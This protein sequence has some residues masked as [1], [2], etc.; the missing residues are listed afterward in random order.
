ML[1]DFGFWAFHWLLYHFGYELWGFAVTSAEFSAQD[2]PR[3]RERIGEELS[4]HVASFDA[5]NNINGDFMF[6]LDQ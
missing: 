3:P 5:Y 4:F 2:A 6:M 1:V